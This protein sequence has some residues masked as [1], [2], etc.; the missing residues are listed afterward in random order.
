LIGLPD[1]GQLRVA[2]ENLATSPTACHGV[3]AV[4]I[5]VEFIENHPLP[6]DEY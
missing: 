1:D 4:M 2:T 3:H 6:D 5:V